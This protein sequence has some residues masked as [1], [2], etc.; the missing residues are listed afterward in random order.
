MSFRR[1]AIAVI[2]LAGLTTGCSGRRCPDETGLHTQPVP[3][4]HYSN[5]NG[6]VV[7][8]TADGLVTITLPPADT[9]SEPVVIVYQVR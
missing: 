4:G 3:V 7:D 6:A 2:A 8:V 5:D 1:E 9:D